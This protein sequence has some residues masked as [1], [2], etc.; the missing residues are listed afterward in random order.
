[1]SPRPYFERLPRMPH[2]AACKSNDEAPPL[3]DAIYCICVQGEDDRAERAAA[4]FHKIGLCRQVTF[5]RPPRGTDIDAAVWASHR[6]V[7]R[8]AM[9]QNR[10]SA[11]ILEDDVEFLVDWPT[12]SRRI[13]R[14]M[15]RL[16]RTWRGFLLGHWPIQSYFVARDVL[17]TRSACA[18][19]YIARQPLLEWI[20]RSR[21]LD[22]AVS[23]LWPG[24]QIDTAIGNLP[25]MYA[26]FPMIA[27]QRP[28]TEFRYNRH[29]KEDGSRRGLFEFDRHRYW[30]IHY[31]MRPA[32][33]I[34]VLASPLHWAIM[35]LRGMGSGQ[36]YHLETKLGPRLKKIREAGLFDEAFY[37][38]ENPDVA[39]AQIDPLTHY[40][41]C[42]EN[43]GR[44]PHPLFNPDCYRSSLDSLLA[45]GESALIHYLEAS[46]EQRKDPHP[47]FDSAWYVSQLLDRSTAEKPPL[48]HYLQSEPSARV[49]PHPCFD[50]AWYRARYADVAASGEA[51]LVHYLK[52]G[53]R[54]GCWP[55]PLFDPDRYFAENPVVAAAGVDPW[56]HY[57]RHRRAKDRA[58][59]VAPSVDEFETTPA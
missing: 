48:V 22:A 2:C 13:A 27:V 29:V 9:A 25:E 54:Q 4:H 18:H 28:P 43:E 41:G 55:H 8:H 38:D 6:D 7:A 23:V 42:G 31:A 49:S 3:V 26:L 44:S 40:V 5:Y 37:L 20:A 45:P 33:V 59:L 15:T 17:R 52:R 30:I 47:C 34:A 32:E 35:Q 57:V 46:P 51:G 56:E 16:P 50:E 58:G 19:A 39:K 11:L 1:M 24:T 36:E 12:A 14:A 21:P 10:A 53:W